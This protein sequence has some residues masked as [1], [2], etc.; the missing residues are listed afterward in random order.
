MSSHHM[1]PS[2]EF[3]LHLVPFRLMLLVFELHTDGVMLGANFYVGICSSPVELSWVIS[4]LLAR[5]QHVLY[6]DLSKQS[7]L[8]PLALVTTMLLYAA[9]RNGSNDKPGH[10]FAG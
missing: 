1:T 7:V 5:E 10:F 6:S 8:M 4:V 2:K 9:T 3:L